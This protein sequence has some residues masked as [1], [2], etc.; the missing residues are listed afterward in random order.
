M[1]RYNSNT[2]LPEQG[3]IIP[4]EDAF[5]AK[6]GKPVGNHFHQFGVRNRDGKP[7]L[8]PT[9]FCFDLGKFDHTEDELYF[10]LGGGFAVMMGGP[11]V[12]I[13]STK[14]NAEV[15]DPDNL[16]EAKHGYKQSNSGLKM[17]V[18]DKDENPNP[19]PMEMRY[20]PAEGGGMTMKAMPSRNAPNIWLKPHV[21]YYVTVRRTHENVVF[22][23]TR[24]NAISVFVT[25][26]G[27]ESK[28]VKLDVTELTGDLF[29]Y[30]VDLGP[31][32]P[33]FFVPDNN[34]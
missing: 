8:N 30:S 28:E 3:E 22:G 32:G 1:K 13:V 21:Q 20:V 23:E 15:G 29:G 6:A 33:G 14:P 26:G 10:T 5:G 17:F 18:N 24:N 11:K 19:V 12:L 7:N 27:D 25:G 16:A 2:F 31:L 4:Y 9:H 34:S